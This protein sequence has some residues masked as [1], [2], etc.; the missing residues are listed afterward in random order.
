VAPDKV[1]QLLNECYPRAKHLLS[2]YWRKQ[3]EKYNVPAVGFC[4]IGAE[5]AYHLLGGKADGWK[6]FYAVYFEEGVRC[7]HWW[8]V[9]QSSIVDPTSK[10][11]TDFKE[12]PP[13]H[14]GRCGGFLTKQPSKR[15][16]VLIDMVKEVL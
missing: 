11:Y 15:A 14:L 5:S 2:P 8:I 6:P 10:Q 4:Y 3:N 12:T 7:T 9:R 16:Q 1:V 13:Y